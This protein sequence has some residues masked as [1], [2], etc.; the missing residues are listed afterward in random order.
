MPS[1]NPQQHRQ[2]PAPPIPRTAN[3]A[4]APAPHLRSP[5]TPRTAKLHAKPRTNHGK[6]PL[7]NCE[8]CG[9]KPGRKSVELGCNNCRKSLCT[10]CR[11][12]RA[13]VKEDGTKQ[14]C[15][16]CRERGP[17][18]QN[19]R[20]EKALRE[21]EQQGQDWTS[22][23]KCPSLSCYAQPA[24]AAGNADAGPYKDTIEKIF[25]EITVFLNSPRAQT[26]GPESFDKLAKGYAELFRVC[27][28]NSPE[29]FFAPIAT[30]AP[31]YLEV[32]DVNGLL[33]GDY[34]ISSPDAEVDSPVLAVTDKQLNEMRGSGQKLPIASAVNGKEEEEDLTG[35]MLLEDF[36]G[37]LT[38]RGQRP[39]MQ[40]S[41]A[42]W[43]DP[44]NVL[45]LSAEILGSAF[46]EPEAVTTLRYRLLSVL[47]KRSIG[48]ST[49]TGIGKLSFQLA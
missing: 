48:H 28:G 7:P 33:R 25:Q 19:R 30:L 32:P 34:E 9:E 31:E 47:S 38:E 36:F 24:R 20:R 46:R 21:C 12:R 42:E 5:V 15:G 22:T 23:T 44:V 27:K 35:F 14:Y 2:F 41:E 45:S 13:S 37:R 11:T 3:P 6:D 18:S 1:A 26:A 8:T 29:D 39:E 10:N 40:R 4:A 17:D 43:K 49:E 16:P